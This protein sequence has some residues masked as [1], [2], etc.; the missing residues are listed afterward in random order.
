MKTI[1]L[2]VKEK[3]THHKKYFL[4]YIYLVYVCTYVYHE[5]ART[6]YMYMYFKVFLVIFGIGKY[7]LILFI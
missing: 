1:V 2:R 3:S 6:W 5:Y 4:P 7:Y